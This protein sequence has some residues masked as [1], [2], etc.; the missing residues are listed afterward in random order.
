VLS[1]DDVVRTLAADMA[2]AACVLDV[3]TP[4]KVAAK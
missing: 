3:Q 4:E 1:L 2:R